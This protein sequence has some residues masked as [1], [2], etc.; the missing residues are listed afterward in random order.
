MDRLLSLAETMLTHIYVTYHHIAEDL[1]RSYIENGR[2]Y[3]IT[4][5]VY[6]LRGVDS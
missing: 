1:G 2:W 6:V 4:D 3:P 5:I